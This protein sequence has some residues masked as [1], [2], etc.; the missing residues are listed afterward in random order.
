MMILI[1]FVSKDLSNLCGSPELRPSGPPGS[2]PVR[3]PSHPIS[4]EA[5]SLTATGSGSF[6]GSG[7]DGS[8][9][10]LS[11]VIHSHLLNSQS[12]LLQSSAANHVNTLTLTNMAVALHT[13][14]EAS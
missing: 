12:V 1:L 5:H 3:M 8:G 11:C 13:P 9:H 4:W 2:V 10:G 7:S 6:L 14:Y